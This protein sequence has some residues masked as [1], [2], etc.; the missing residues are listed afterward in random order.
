M[1]ARWKL[2]GWHFTP[3]ENIEGENEVIDSLQELRDSPI[4]GLDIDKNPL[5]STVECLFEN[6]EDLYRRSLLPWEQFRTVFDC[7]AT[8]RDLLRW[9]HGTYSAKIRRAARERFWELM[10][11]S[12]F[13]VNEIPNIHA[14]QEVNWPLPPIT[15]RHAASL[16]VIVCI[17]EAIEALESVLSK[18]KIESKPFL[19]G[20]PFEWLASND[21]AYLEAVVVDILESANQRAFYIEQIRDAWDSHNQAELWLS[22]VDTLDFHQAEIERTTTRTKAQAELQTLA[23]VK[24][25]TSIRARAAAKK[26]RGEAASLTPQV[27]AEYFKAHPNQ[28]WE[29]AVAELAAAYG[30]STSTVARRHKKAKEENLLS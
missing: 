2:R 6:L 23:R 21:P 27:V 1:R 15:E 12:R 3:L 11:T 19:R 18:W 10:T 16:A 28:K 29:V 5:D 9:P 4:C 24:A 30:V 14:L 13:S 7:K 26:H 8:Q 20:K 17:I 25:E 22:H